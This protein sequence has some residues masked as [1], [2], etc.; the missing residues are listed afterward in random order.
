MTLARRIWPIVV[1]P[2]GLMQ[3]PLLWDHTGTGM[4]GH[5][6]RFPIQPFTLLDLADVELL[7][8]PIENGADLV[9]VLEA[10]TEPLFARRGWQDPAVRRDGYALDGAA[11]GEKSLRRCRSG[12][13]IRPQTYRGG[14]SRPSRREGRRSRLRL[15]A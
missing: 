12:P 1:A 5:F 10:K 13:R 14:R 3:H 4:A 9:A 11:P 2:A 7:A 8:G 15:T 6:K